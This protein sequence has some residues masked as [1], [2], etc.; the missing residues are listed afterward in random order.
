MVTIA[1]ESEGTKDVRAQKAF[2]IVRPNR[3]AVDRNRATDRRRDPLPI[4]GEVFPMEACRQAY[5]HKPLRG[6]HVLRVAER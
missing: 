5:E 3:G 6:K 4:W 1:A 2:F